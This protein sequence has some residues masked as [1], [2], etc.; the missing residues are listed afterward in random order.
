MQSRRKRSFARMMT[1]EAFSSLP[2]VSRKEHQ[3]L[4]DALVHTVSGKALGS[5]ENGCLSVVRIF[6]VCESV[7][8]YRNEEE[9]EEVRR[10][11]R[12]ADISLG[13]SV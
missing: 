13:T 1:E 9:E 3:S 11:Q 8:H 10:R 2:E 5:D 4:M 6:H 7:G 12:Y